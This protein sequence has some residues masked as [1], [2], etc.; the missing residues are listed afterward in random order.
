MQRN[1]KSTFLRMMKHVFI[2]KDIS[3]GLDN[4][5]V[6]HLKKKII[7]LKLNFKESLINND[8][9]KRE[10]RKTILNLNEGDDAESKTKT[11]EATKG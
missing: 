1:I 4:H 3:G 7:K 5:P 8:G 9:N 11:K 10:M 6:D 2:S